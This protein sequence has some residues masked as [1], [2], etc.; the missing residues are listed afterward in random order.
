MTPDAMT[1][2]LPAPTASPDAAAVLLVDDRRENL[3]ALEATLAPLG[4]RLVRA[5]SADEALRH[6]LRESFAVILLDVQ[7]PGTDGLATARLLK[8]RAKSEHI[9]II[10]LTAL[11]QDR[12]HATLGYESGAVD[13]LF[14]PLDPDGLR[15]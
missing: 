4:L 1:T 8:Q 11:D 15:A 2:A 9:P 10:F 7:M 14:K 6:V 5:G 3:L 13:Y 12:R